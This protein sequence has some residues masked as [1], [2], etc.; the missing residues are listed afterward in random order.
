MEK[1]VVDFTAMLQMRH[2][3]Q[4]GGVYFLFTLF[5]TQASMF[6]VLK[7]YVENNE[8]EELSDDYHCFVASLLIVRSACCLSF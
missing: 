5:Y 7:L 3:K 4:M 2:P 1:V 6:V 8:N